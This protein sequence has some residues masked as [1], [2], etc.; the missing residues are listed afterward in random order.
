MSGENWRES[1]NENYLGLFKQL[2]QRVGMLKQLSKVVPSGKF[3]M[4]YSMEYSIVNCSIV[5]KYSVMCGAMMDT[6]SFLGK[7]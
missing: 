7:A 1:S 4:L 3:R 2:S 5:C 6:V